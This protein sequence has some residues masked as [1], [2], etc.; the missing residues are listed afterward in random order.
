MGH[1]QA[2]LHA[3][4]KGP[5]RIEQRKVENVTEFVAVNQLT[6]SV[7]VLPSIALEDAA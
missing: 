3:D 5:V 2:V 6:G 1:R 7:T 4:L